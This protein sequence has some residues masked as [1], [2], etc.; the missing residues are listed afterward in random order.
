MSWTVLRFYPVFVLQVIKQYSNQNYVI[1]NQI[2][3]EISPMEIASYFFLGC[4][5]ALTDK[6]IIKNI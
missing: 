3:R 5:L 1:I 4:T 6:D 2:L